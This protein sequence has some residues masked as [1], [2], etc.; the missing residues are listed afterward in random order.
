MHFHGIHPSAMDGVPG[1]GEEIGGGLIQPGESF[2]YEFD[3]EPFGLHLYHCHA[4]P[5]AAHIA[6]GL[7]GTFIVDPKEPR[8]RGRRARDGDERLR[9]ELRLRQRGLRRQHRRAST[10]STT[11]SRSSA[12]SWCASTWSTCSST[13]RSTPS[14]CTPTSSTTSRPGR[15]SQPAE[16]TDTISQVPGAARDPRAAVPV[17]GQVHVPRPQDRVRRARLDG[18]LRGRGLM[19]RRGRGRDARRRR[20]SGA[21]PVAARRSS[22]SRS[23]AA[24]VVA[25]ALLG[26]PGLGERRGPPVEELVVD[27]IALHPGV[28]E[29][30]VRNDGPDAVAVAQVDRQRRLRAT[31]R[32]STTAIGRLGG[33]HAQGR[34]PVDRGRG[35]RD[36]AADLD[37][38]H[39]RSRDPRRGRDAP[40]PDAGFYGLMALLGTYVGVDPGAAGHALAAA[41]CGASSR[42]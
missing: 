21:R 33:R 9:H 3:A 26:A 4:T 16:Y 6:K 28:I 10:T 31:S 8:A 30:T 18:L 13:T 36:L 27:K 25:F 40:R 41:A 32:A 7:Y 38:R 35:L 22:R 37:R 14:T 23:C 12:T 5:L 34:L 24:I 2:T 19:S 1:L 17:P 11:R 20:R 39:D 42:R 29:L 15:R